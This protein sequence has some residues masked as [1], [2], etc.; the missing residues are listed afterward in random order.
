MSSSGREALKGSERPPLHLRD[1]IGGVRIEAL[2]RLL[3]RALDCSRTAASL[4]EMPNSVICQARLRD[5]AS[6][7]R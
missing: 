2:A 3:V 7:T 4:A 6:G 1:R 5:P